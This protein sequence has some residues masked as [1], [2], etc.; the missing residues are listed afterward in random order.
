MCQSMAEALEHSLYIS[1]NCINMHTSVQ[2]FNLEL[3][4]LCLCFLS[5][6]RAYGNL[7]LPLT[8]VNPW[9]VIC[10]QEA[11]GLYIT[12]HIPRLLLYILQSV[13]PLCLHILLEAQVTFCWLYMSPLPLPRKSSSNPISR[14]S[15]LILLSLCF[16]N[17]PYVMEWCLPLYCPSCH[18]L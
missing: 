17:I 10:L 15:R 3:F 18:R 6:L 16:P 4:G 8:P 13:N 12:A 11:S 5:Y 2:S 1:G 7:S 9:L 14:I